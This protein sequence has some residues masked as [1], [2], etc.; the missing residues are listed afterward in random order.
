MILQVHDELVFDIPP[1]EESRW[2]TIINESMEGVLLKHQDGCT[3]YVQDKIM[4]PFR[5]DI[6]TGKNWSEAKG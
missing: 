5:V 6:H 4:I 1:E 2:F 3:L